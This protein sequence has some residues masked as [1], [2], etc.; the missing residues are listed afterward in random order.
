MNIRDGSELRTLVIAASSERRKL[1][2]GVVDRVVRTRAI[3]DASISLERIF[4]SAVDLIVVDVDTPSVAAAILR[5]AQA[6]PGGTGLI[7]LA[8]N[9]DASWVGEALRAGVN[10]ILSREINA[11]EIRLGILAAEAG[12]VLLHPSSAQNL[13]RRTLA[14]EHDADS[15]E[16]LTAREQEVLQLVSL[17][18][19]NKEIAARLNISDHT[20]KF[21]IS[22]ILGKLG[23]ATRTEAVSE[24]IRKG[25]ITI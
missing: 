13:G 2:A 15:L 16:A 20:V 6:L 5:I 11:E 8:D 7:V 3:V 14:L 22:S 24:G 19:G 4:Q 21:H 18:L 23:A 12:L 9:P 1:M 17:G 10:A 25:F